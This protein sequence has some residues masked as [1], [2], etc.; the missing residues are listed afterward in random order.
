MT[1]LKFYPEAITTFVRNTGL[2]A[3]VL[4]AALLSGCA[5]LIAPQSVS[6]RDQ[7]PADLPARAELKQVPFFPQTEYQCGPAALATVLA[8]AR[9]KVKPDDLVSQVYVPDRKG[10]FQV[11]MLAAARR[12]GMISYEL[13]P[14]YEDVLREVA[15]G[16]P[17]ILLQN[18]GVGPFDNWHYAVAVG[19]DLDDNHLV[20]RSGDKQRHVMNAG[21]NEFVWRKS[22]YWAMVVV[23]PNRI[24]ATAHEESWL[25]AIAAF[26]RV[27]HPRAARVAYAT[28]LRRWPENI[29]A[30]IGLANT[31]HATKELKEAERV[32]RA[33]LARDPDSVVV[34]NNL[35]QTLSDQGR[36][37]EALAYINRA[38]AA[39]GPF[40]GA[41]GETRA[42]ILK[43]TQR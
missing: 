10:S 29:N 5:S 4:A 42:L 17:V 28:F 30:S 15:A 35:A 2:A 40:A 11:E 22:G 6:L 34:L 13:A 16:T 1:S 3:L 23:P 20:L 25:A 19:Y 31:Y 26:E 43:R 9:V 7:R 18:L 36:N 14:Q 27:G 32:L 41:V 21:L 33:A 24:P 38:A 37:L 8:N 39:G 12:H